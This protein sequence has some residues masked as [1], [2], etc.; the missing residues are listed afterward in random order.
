MATL[1]D[2]SAAGT[3]PVK[4]LLGLNGL[5][6]FEIQNSRQVQGATFPLGIAAKAGHDFSDIGSAV[7]TIDKLAEKGVFDELLRQRRV[8]LKNEKDTVG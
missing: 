2:S 3:D 4:G 1:Q 6:I 7:N 8:Y 5:E